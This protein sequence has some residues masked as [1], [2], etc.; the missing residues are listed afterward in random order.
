MLSSHDVTQDSHA[1]F[2]TE[3]CDAFC[4]DHSMQGPPYH[5]GDTEAETEGLCQLRSKLQSARTAEKEGIPGQLLC[6]A[7][8]YPLYDQRSRPERGGNGC[9]RVGEPCQQ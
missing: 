5:L 1:G 2:L 4:A 6:R 7:Y 3:T 8:C 9:R